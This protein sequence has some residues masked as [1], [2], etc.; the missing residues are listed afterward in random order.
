MSSGLE[1]VFSKENIDDNRG[2]LSNLQG[3]GGVAAV[4]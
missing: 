2:E 3:R 4:F 1:P